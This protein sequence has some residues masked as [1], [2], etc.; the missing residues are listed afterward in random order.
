MGRKFL[1][2]RSHSLLLD[3][4]GSCS[5]TCFQPAATP[6]SRVISFPFI[7]FR[8]PMRRAFCSK[9]IAIAGPRNAMP[10]LHM[11]WTLLGWWYSRGL[12]WWERSIALAFAAFTVLAAMGTGEH[13]CV[14]LVVAFPFALM[15]QALCAYNLRWSDLRRLQARSL[16]LGATFA[17]LVALRY[18]NRV[19][20]PRQLLPG[21]SSLPPSH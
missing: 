21:H 17:W 20:G 3:R 6:T 19:S 13:Y 11:A 9:P 8:S 5:T 18:A 14:D 2:P 10:S 16:G 1:R 4:S 12:S 15:I 7:R